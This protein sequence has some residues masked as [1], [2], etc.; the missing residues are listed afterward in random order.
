MTWSA[1]RTITTGDGMAEK[2]V[3]FGAGATGRGHVGWLAWQAGFEIVFV[4][5]KP[6]FVEALGRAGRY[7]VK[8]YG[9]RCRE[10][11]V[12]GCRVYHHL[13]R[14]RIADETRDAALILTAVFDQ[15]LLDVAQTISQGVSA[16]RRAGR[17]R[18]LNCIACENMTD[19]SSTLGRHVRALLSAEDAAWC[20]QDV[21]FPDSMSRVVPRPEPPR[22]DAVDSFL[23][24][25]QT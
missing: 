4:D 24:E 20:D 15:N 12:S 25:N 1:F 14:A 3:V 6:E 9:Q 8:L 7:L 17:V 16:C 19:S 10:I 5:K 21:G 13:D 22:R 11:T 23:K 18:P 2:L